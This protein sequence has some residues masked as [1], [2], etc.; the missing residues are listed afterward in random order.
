[1][2]LFLEPQ[3]G[4]W[5]VEELGPGAGAG[6]GV[7]EGFVWALICRLSVVASTVT[8]PFWSVR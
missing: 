1:M 6:A 7:A 2:L 4:P 8:S 3:N 5:E